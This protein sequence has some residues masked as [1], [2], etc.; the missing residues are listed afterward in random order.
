MSLYFEDQK[1]GEANPLGAHTFTREGIIAFAVLYDP[2]P[3]HTSDEGG[4]ASI[5]GSLIASGWH[6]ASV[7]MRLLIDRRDRIKAE[8]AALGES[9]PQL[10][11][12]SGRHSLVLHVKINLRRRPIHY[13]LSIQLHI[14][15]VYMRPLDPA[16]CL[17][18]LGH[19]IRR[20]LGKAFF[21]G[22][23]HL[24]NLLRHHTLLKEV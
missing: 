22:S 24:D 19:G 4:K 11:V 17:A 16:H 14:E 12:Q 9:A 15:R 7:C 2:Q 21:R 23:N 18:R 5:F 13:F 10:G 1:V 8:R 6:T 3:F 20:R